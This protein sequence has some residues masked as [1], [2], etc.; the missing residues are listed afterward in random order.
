MKNALLEDLKVR[1]QSCLTLASARQFKSI[2]FPTLSTGTL[3]Y[4]PD[5]VAEAMLTAI[6]DF[7][8]EMPH[9]SLQ[10]VCICCYIKDKEL[11]KVNLYVL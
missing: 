10:H 7:F 4:P 11:I 9:S 8:R 3:N 5:R 6:H 1:V 2:V